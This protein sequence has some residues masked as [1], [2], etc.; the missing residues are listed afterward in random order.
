MSIP[1]HEIHQIQATGTTQAGQP[2]VAIDGALFV[3]VGEFD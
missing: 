1:A 2:V 3:V